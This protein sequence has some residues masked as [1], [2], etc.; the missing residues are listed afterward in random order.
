MGVVGQGSDGVVAAGR[1]GGL[2]DEAPLAVLAGGVHADADVRDRGLD[3]TVD[4]RAGA[5]LERR[6]GRRALGLA[7][8]RQY[9]KINY[10]L[11]K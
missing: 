7:P 2:R 11:I 3:A 9:I 5:G 1:G 8:A 6:E 4:I 10:K